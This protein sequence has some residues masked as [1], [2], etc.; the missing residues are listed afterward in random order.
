L[1]VTHLLVL[2]ERSILNVAQPT[3]G[4]GPSRFTTELSGLT[5][6]SADCARRLFE[7]AEPEPKTVRID[8]EANNEGERN[9]FTSSQEDLLS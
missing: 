3:Y 9:Y 4:A 2:P 1:K 5:R 8:D 6:S 7:F